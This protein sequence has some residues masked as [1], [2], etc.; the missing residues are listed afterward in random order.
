MFQNRH[1]VFLFVCSIVFIQAIYYIITLQ[2]KRND[3]TIF[4]SPN[5]IYNQTSD[6]S[7]T[8]VRQANINISNSSLLQVS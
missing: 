5:L 6:K 3:P 1:T 4:G 8:S 7:K 2:I